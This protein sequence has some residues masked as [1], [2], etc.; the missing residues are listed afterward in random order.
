M[1]VA[2]AKNSIVDNRVEGWRVRCLGLREG[3]LLESNYYGIVAATYTI[4]S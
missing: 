2:K 4:V 1:N 3:L